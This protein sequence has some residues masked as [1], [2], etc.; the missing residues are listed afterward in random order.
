[1]ALQANLLV[2]KLKK[3]LLSTSEWHLLLVIGVKSYK[4]LKVEHCC[5]IKWHE[6]GERCTLCSKRKKKIHGI[7]SFIKEEL[8]AIIG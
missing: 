5:H 7:V 4:A 1:M 3:E 2:L 6:E 8:S